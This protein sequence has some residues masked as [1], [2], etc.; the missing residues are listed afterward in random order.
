MVEID[1]LGLIIPVEENM[2]YNFHSADITDVEVSKS[3][4]T[5]QFKIPKTL[6]I[7]SRL[8]GLGIA[9]DRSDYAYYS[10]RVVVLENS[11]P[12]YEG[13]FV[14][15]R[16]D[17]R[18]YYCTIIAGT[19]DF[20]NEID[21]V[22]FSDLDIEEIVHPKTVSEVNDKLK[23]TNTDPI[24][25]FLANFG[26]YPN[27]TRDD[28]LF[29]NIDNLS[30][31]VSIQYLLDKVSEYSGFELEV[32]NEVMQRINPSSAYGEV[33]R[34]V[35]P[36]PPYL[37]A[38]S[39][40]EVVASGRILNRSGATLPQSGGYEFQNYKYFDNRSAINTYFTI[41]NDWRFRAN[42][43]GEYLI[44]FPFFDVLKDDSRPDQYTIC[45]VYRNGVEIAE[46]TNE[47]NQ[48]PVDFFETSVTL[49]IGDLIDFSLFFNIAPSASAR[50]YNI[51]D[52]QF[53]ILSADIS[54]EGREDIYGLSLK[55][56][57]KE[58]CFRFGL[59]PTQ[60]SSNKIK[61]VQIKDLTNKDLAINWTGKY[62]RRKEESYDNGFGVNNYLR[63]K[64][65]DEVVDYHDKNFV[66]DNKNLQTNNNLITSEFYAPNGLTWLNTGVEI[67]Q[68]YL[69]P[70]YELSSGERSKTN[71]RYMF[72]ST[73]KQRVK[74]R[75]GSATLTGISYSP[76]GTIVNV[77]NY[78]AYFSGNEFWEPLKYFMTNPR[79]QIIE[80][81]LKIEDIMNID[82][83]RPY[84]FEQ[85]AGYFLIKSLKYTRGRLATAECIKI[86]VPDVGND[87]D[88]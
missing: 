50:V 59:L 10:T 22:R 72:T 24:I 66:S 86:D 43:Y 33:E 38:G 62:H 74:Y 44:R 77:G 37:E 61:F 80:L 29:L 18:Y 16:S 30:P 19:K 13:T 8:D 7:Q 58:F 78:N 71:N 81:H 73:F 4:Y 48:D 35:F 1:L 20:F 75:L 51:R 63:H 85:E 87:F 56:F 65:S 67:I 31:A 49:D 36:Y 45:K 42:R 21:G 5:S 55:T 60:P 88:I 54:T 34:I 64:Y 41:I 26:G 39:D 82:L 76:D 52:I 68:S 46:F 57:I 3:N 17:D 28:N 40:G 47:T 32:P 2:S 14:I 84:Y 25:Y 11:I 12:V 79:I 23:G 53:N 69:Y 9:G 70:I 83:A 27:F 15:L 6:E